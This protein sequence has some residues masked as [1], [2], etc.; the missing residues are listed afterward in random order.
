MGAAM[1]SQ[2]TLAI[3]PQPDDITCGPTCLHAVY[4]Y[5]GDDPALET[6]IREVQSL[7]SG[8]TLAVYLA[9]HALNR[10]YNATIYTYNL[11]M[12]DPSW[13]ERRD[14][15]R[16]ADKLK[17]QAAVKDNPRIRDATAAYLEFLRLGGELR[18]QVVE[19]ELIRKYLRRGIPVLTGLSATYL[20]QA[21]RE[22]PADNA[23][24]DVRGEPAGHFVVLCGYDKENR[25][26]L[27]ADPYL[28]NPL[29]GGQYYTVPM[30]R[31]LGALLL[32]V[33]THDANFL[34]IR[35]GAGRRPP[36]AAHSRLTVP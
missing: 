7:R 25:A 15:V 35:P 5:F 14:P 34:I 19:A 20:Y 2:L 18:Y 1:P 13:F 29:G 23:A 8:G 11:H 10:G 9:C 4:R 17:A 36:F 3:H 28:Q 21:A 6:V 30:T 22:R 32:G 12:F 24:D 27:V 16:L 26:V 31:L 33:L